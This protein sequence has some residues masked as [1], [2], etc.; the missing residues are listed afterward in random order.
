MDVLSLLYY[1]AEV[2]L[3]GI[4]IYFVIGMMPMPPWA[5][6][7]CQTLWIVLCVLSVIAV[8]LGRPPQAMSRAGPGTPGLGLGPLPNIM[9]GN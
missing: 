4:V 5:T 1:A 2:A 9:R 6:R 8:V 3:F 7:V